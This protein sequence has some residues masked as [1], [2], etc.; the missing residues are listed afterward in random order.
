MRLIYKYSSTTTLRSPKRIKMVCQRRSTGGLPL[1]TQWTCTF[2]RCLVTTIS[3]KS[4]ALLNYPILLAAY[5]ATYLV[6]V[7]F[8]PLIQPRIIHIIY[9]PSLVSV[10]MRPS[11]SF[12]GSTSLF[13]GM[14]KK[15]TLYLIL[16]HCYATVIMRV[17]MFLPTQ[18]N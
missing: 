8:Q 10:T 9:R 1:R 4:S 5:T 11:L 7:N 2:S 15:I 17:V 14:Q 12:C 13:T 16:A 3:D 6:R 18:E